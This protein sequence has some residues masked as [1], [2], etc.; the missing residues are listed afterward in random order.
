MDHLGAA[1]A[2]L[3]TLPS[4]ETAGK[5]VAA[6]TVMATGRQLIEAF[7]NLHNGTP[8]TILEY[9]EETRKA[10]YANPPFGPVSA[11]YKRHWETGKWEYPAQV[12]VETYDGKGDTVE[13]IAKKWL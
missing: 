7:T 10:D 12:P 1:L 13:Q 3:A 5:E 11:T 6:V 2:Y 9:D 4:A 8:P